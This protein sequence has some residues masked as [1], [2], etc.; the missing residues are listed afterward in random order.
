M[1]IAMLLGALLLPAHVAAVTVLSDVPVPP[2]GKIEIIGEDAVHNGTSISMG[3][4]IASQSIDS[5]V[6]FYEQAWP[7][8]PSSDMPGMIQT[9]TPEWLLLSHLSDGYNTVIQLSLATTHRSTGYVSVMPVEQLSAAQ[10][11]VGIDD[12]QLLSDTRT[13]DEFSSSQLSVYAS[14]LPVSLLTERLV[15]TRINGH[16]KVTS[17]REFGDSQIVLMSARTGQLELIVS[18][19]D[20]V[21]S[22]AV[23]NEVSPHD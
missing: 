7:D 9:S 23:I 13:K 2:G 14:V 1:R 10:P 11:T 21:G 22:I 15:R 12:L 4:F 19:S 18:R 8:S 5:T 6:A 3:T 17:K 20:D 16:W